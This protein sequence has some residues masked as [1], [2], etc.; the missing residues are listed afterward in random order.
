MPYC[1]RM[2]DEKYYKYE[3]KDFEKLIE[4]FKQ[5]ENDVGLLREAKLRLEY[6]MKQRGE[7]YNK[8]INKNE[9]YNANEK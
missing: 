7:S 4:E 9:I 3:D 6:E 2:F 1:R 5:L 8:R